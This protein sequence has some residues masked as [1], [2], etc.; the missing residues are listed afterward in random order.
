MFAAQHFPVFGQQNSLR[1]GNGGSGYRLR[2][3]SFGDHPIFSAEKPETSI[4]ISGSS[5]DSRYFS[6]DPKGEVARERKNVSFDVSIPSPK[7]SVNSLVA[8]KIDV[9][10]KNDDNVLFSLSAENAKA[11]E[12]FVFD[13]KDSNGNYLEEGCGQPRSR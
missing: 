5:V 7:A 2:E 3:S 13:G 10:G 6:P 9:V 8:W 12:K 1:P 11:P 4:A